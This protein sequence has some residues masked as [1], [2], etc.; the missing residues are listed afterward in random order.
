MVQS[1]FEV[2]SAY[3]TTEPLVTIAAAS[4]DQH[5]QELQSYLTQ[6]GTTKPAVLPIKGDEQLLLVKTAT[7]ILIDVVAGTLQVTTT[8]G[9]VTTRERLTHL[10]QRLAN[11]SFV[12]VSKHAVLN[13]DQ[14]QALA[15]S[16]SGN[17]TAKLTGGVQTA[18]SRK[19]VKSLMQQLGV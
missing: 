12:Q 8:D 2:N 17:L 13:L 15:D 3:S 1:Q 4:Q 6:F 11:P 5:I 14:L 7:I 9:V 16:F 18:V 10:L 19:Y